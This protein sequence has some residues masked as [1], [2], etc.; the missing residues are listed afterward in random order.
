[1]ETLLT[2][3]WFWLIQYIWF[4]PLVM[5]ML[6]GFILGFIEG[7]KEAWTSTKGK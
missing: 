3:P 1:M 6:S 5:I 4:G 7:F 2:N